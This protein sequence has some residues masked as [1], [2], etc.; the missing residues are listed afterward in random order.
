ML[1]N[2]CT[3]INIISS[4]SKIIRIISRVSLGNEEL[5]KKGG[6]SEVGGS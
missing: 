3:I 6:R 2:I 1:Q 5:T 4:N